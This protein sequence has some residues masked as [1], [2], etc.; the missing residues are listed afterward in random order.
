MDFFLKLQHEVLR[1]GDLSAAVLGE[2][3][4]FSSQTI[5]R[6]LTGPKMPSRRVV[7]ALAAALGDEQLQNELMTFWVAGVAESRESPSLESYSPTRDSR[8]T[9]SAELAKLKDESGL[10]FRALAHRIE[11]PSGQPVM[12]FT[13]IRDY[14]QGRSLPSPDR[15]MLILDAL[16]VKSQAERHRWR[17][18]LARASRW[19]NLPR[20]GGSNP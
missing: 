7:T 19:P 8:E 10:S 1:H 12:S 9:F 5:Y 6:A 4:G 2:L 18:S 11:S 20:S 3:T 13:T 14:I 16:G 15:L 17:E